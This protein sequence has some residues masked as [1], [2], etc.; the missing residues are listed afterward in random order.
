MSTYPWMLV[1]YYEQRSE[2]GTTPE[3][4]EHMFA[5]AVTTYI[6]RQRIDRSYNEAD[7]SHASVTFQM[8][9]KTYIAT[10]CNLTRHTE[11]MRI[12]LFAS[13]LITTDIRGTGHNGNFYM[14]WKNCE[15]QYRGNTTSTL[16]RLCARKKL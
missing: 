6:Q 11:S 13:R 3:I 12:C 16:A 5:I 10:G 14:S 4:C 2:Y 7:L 1:V 15:P 9:P 8:C